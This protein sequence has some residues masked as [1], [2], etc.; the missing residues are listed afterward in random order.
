MAP[1]GGQDGC[2]K[3]RLSQ[4]VRKGNGQIVMTYEINCR[5]GHEIS[6]GTFIATQLAQRGDVPFH[7]LVGQLTGC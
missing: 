7:L 2:D 3:I 5:N 6:R 1:G 4:L